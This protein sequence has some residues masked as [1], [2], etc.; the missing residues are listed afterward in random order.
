MYK[1]GDQ[2]NLLHLAT[3]MPSPAP[4]LAVQDDGDDDEEFEYSDEEED[5]DDV[6]WEDV[7]QE[8][9]LRADNDAG[10][11]D[12]EDDEALESADDGG[13]DD[14]GDED[15]EQEEEDA[16]QGDDE[17]FETKARA[18]LQKVDW[19]QV[20]RALR[21]EAQKAEAATVA[22]GKRRR[23]LR[24][25]KADKARELALHESHLLLLLATQLQWNALCQTPVLRA[26]LLSLTAENG[27]GALDFYAEMTR[28]PLKYALEV[29]VRWFHQH[30]RVLTAAEAAAA[31]AA[32]AEE[33]EEMRASG[34]ARELL[35]EAR[36]M[37]VFFDRKGRDHELAVLFTAL[38][39]SLRL[40]CRHTC[41][42][43]ALR[44][45]QTTAFEAASS[46]SPGTRGDRVRKRPRTQ[47]AEAAGADA[48]GD[49]EQSVV[50]ATQSF[51]VWCEVYDEKRRAWLHVDAVRKAVGQP[52]EVEALR[53]KGAPLSYIVS[54]TPSEHLVDVTPRYVG[55]WSKCLELRI[56]HEWMARALEQ[57][58]RER[59]DRRRPPPIGHNPFESS[60]A[61]EQA[62][63]EEQTKLLALTESEEMPT[64][65]E[66]FK[67][68]HLFC[69]E[70]HL[71]RFECVHPRKAVGIFKGQPVF[72]RR[73]VQL[74]RSSY[75]WRRLGREVLEAEQHQPA[76]WYARGKQQGADSGSD[77][78][79]PPPTGSSSSDGRRAMFGVWQTRAFVAPPVVNGVVPK[80]S[81]GNI[82][83]WSEAHVPRGGVHVRLPRIE[84]VA[85][86]L[87]VDF[88][89]AVVGFEVRGD[90]NVPQ[91]DGIVVAET[92]LELLLDAHAHVQQGTIERAIA[93]NQT[94]VL[95]RWERLM[96]RLLLRQRLEDDY[97]VVG[98]A[99][100]A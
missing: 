5:D 73:Q 82:E 35:T 49:D 8:A 86:E 76:K 65:L 90:R 6:A 4:A 15:Y 53:G 98:G 43:D 97:G 51:W 83:V 9:Q 78:D 3:R 58:N 88:A 22:R 11:G 29:L 64:S 30:F 70:R 39:R 7:Q 24:L 93:K 80:N 21:Q 81:Y 20:N 16:E 13:D 2:V 91:T 40:Y 96:K 52:Q 32:R 71:G 18:D 19:E 59:R 1:T 89:P 60:E 85:L 72:L 38:C 56:A 74:T 92:A 41:A 100:T 55:R 67:K 75:Q 44:M 68:H 94:V 10:A 87:G 48:G 54:I 26:L 25:S 45:R 99:D 66:A 37:Q 17:R 77:S 63:V 61:E 42:L 36:L 27:G 14:D 23:A 46:T 33:E 12:D 34:R 28:Q 69:L 47:S 57:L 50:E 31:A 84:K 95:K 62:L 79:A